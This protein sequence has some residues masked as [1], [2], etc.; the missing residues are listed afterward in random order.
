MPLNPPG[1]CPGVLPLATVSFL[2]HTLFKGPIPTLTLVANSSGCSFSTLNKGADSACK[3]LPP[4]TRRTSYSRCIRGHSSSYGSRSLNWGPADAELLQAGTQRQKH[5]G[6]IT[7]NG[8]RCAPLRDR[9]AADLDYAGEV[10]SIEAPGPDD[11]PTVTVEQ[12]DT[13]ESVPL[14]LDQIPHIDKPDLM[15]GRGMLGTFIGI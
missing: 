4:S 9:L 3:G 12:Q 1:R 10:L 2:D 6:I 5:P 7:D 15:R 13:V 14:D 11:G 8:V